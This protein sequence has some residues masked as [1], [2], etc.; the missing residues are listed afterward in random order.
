MSIEFETD[1]VFS[2][3]SKFSKFQ[4]V[5]YIIG[6]L[7]IG[8][9]MFQY[10]TGN[11]INARINTA[12]QNESTYYA[13]YDNLLDLKLNYENLWFD[14]L[15]LDY[16]TF[17]EVNTMGKDPTEAYKDLLVYLLKFTDSWYNFKDIYLKNYDN[18]VIQWLFTEEIF[19]FWFYRS[20]L[21]PSQKNS[22]I[23]DEMNRFGQVVLTQEDLEQWDIRWINED[24]IDFAFTYV[25]TSFIYNETY[26]AYED[27][28]EGRPGY[29]EVHL[30]LFEEYINS[31][32]HEPKKILID[33]LAQV[34]NAALANTIGVLIMSFLIDFDSVRKG[35]KRLYL[36][37]MI[38]VVIVNV[39]FAISWFF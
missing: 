35:L 19:T 36:I 2:E 9:S 14:L 30:D 37:L 39:G 34:E 4:T 1:N 28:L 29:I 32:F 3:R 33:Q 6:L 16:K 31:H 26:L 17:G 10:F 27:N 13:L 7:F 18:P 25:Y 20:S 12:E 11:A 15:E 5:I 38:P 22:Q 8:T 24:G 21:T 23:L